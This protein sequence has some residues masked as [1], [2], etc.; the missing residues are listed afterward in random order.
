M[1]YKGYVTFGNYLN[2]TNQIFVEV[3]SSST[4]LIES[5]FSFFVYMVPCNIIF[6]LFF[7]TL[8]KILSRFPI[9]KYL[10]RYK[11]FK[12]M[13]IKVLLLENVSY[14]VFVSLNHIHLSFHFLFGDKL[15][16]IFTLLYLFAIFFLTF[17]F[18]W[19][20][21]KHCRKFSK[22]F[23]ENIRPLK[24]SVLFLTCS[25]M[26][27][28]FIRGSIFCLLFDFPSPQ[29]ISLIILKIL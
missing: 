27:I 7:K 10:K 22:F 16:L 9:K 24:K 2:F 26:I 17:T 21:M 19:M 6:C 1:H 23:M 14:F 4:V 8:F 28:K 18:Y 29:I 13:V 11:Y 12:T 25:K 3:E 20:G 15:N 5:N